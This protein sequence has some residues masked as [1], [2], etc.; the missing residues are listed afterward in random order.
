MREVFRHRR[1]GT[2]CMCSGR[3]PSAEVTGIEPNEVLK[4]SMIAIS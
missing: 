1:G 3:E 4:R 2:A